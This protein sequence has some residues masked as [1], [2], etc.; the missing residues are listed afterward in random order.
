MLTSCRKH[1]TIL[2]TLMN[3]MRLTALM[4]LI[5]LIALMILM[6]LL[7]L[8]DLRALMVLIIVTD[9]IRIMA[10]TFLIDLIAHVNV[11]WLNGSTKDT[12]HDLNSAF[13]KQKKQAHQ[14]YCLE[15]K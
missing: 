13:F 5:D 8:M 4:I 11:Y 14:L 1:K 6:A 3:L 10:L 12:I 2:M 9:L 15:P 7:G